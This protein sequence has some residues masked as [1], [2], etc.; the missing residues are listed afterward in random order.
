MTYHPTTEVLPT[1]Q[2]GA[3]AARMG[4]Q[5]R[6]EGAHRHPKA[7]AGAHRGCGITPTGGHPGSQTGGP[8]RATRTPSQKHPRYPGTPPRTP[9]RGRPP[10][11]LRPFHGGS[12]A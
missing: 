7:D 4:T 5:G 8:R 9:P 3:Q 10:L 6:P 11:P 2:G 12:P 1:Q